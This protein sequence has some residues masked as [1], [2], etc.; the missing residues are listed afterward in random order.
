MCVCVTYM[1][2][3]DVALVIWTIMVDNV[4]ASFSLT[5][6]SMV[7]VMGLPYSVGRRKAYVF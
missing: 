1:I 3:G 5:I 7:V 6:E 2:H 4:S